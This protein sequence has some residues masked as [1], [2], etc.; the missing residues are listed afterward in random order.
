MCRVFARV[1]VF[2]CVVLLHSLCVYQL[3]QVGVI[4]AGAL[5]L[6]VQTPLR[7]WGSEESQHG[8]QVFSFPEPSKYSLIWQGFHFQ[9]LRRIVGFETP[10]RLGSV[11]SYITTSSETCILTETPDQTCKI[12]GDYSIQFSPGVDGDYSFPGV[13]YSGL[14]SANLSQLSI[15]SGNWSFTFSDNSSQQPVLHAETVMSLNASIV[16]NEY[17]ST[18]QSVEVILQ[19]F[20]IEMK[21]LATSEHACNSNAVWAYYF[22]LSLPGSC[23]IAADRKVQ[24]H[25]IFSVSLLCIIH[26]LYIDCLLPTAVC[27]WPWVNSHPWRGKTL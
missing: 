27:T 19:G 1:Y 24:L 21:C 8:Q 11:A 6:N 16:F 12:I 15:L 9:C 25:C 14:A 7:G 18:S 17:L 26:Y 22:N 3:S 13:Y 20:R 23:S 10:H 2:P 5:R 4:P